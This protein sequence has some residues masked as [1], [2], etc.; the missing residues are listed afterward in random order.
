MFCLLRLLRV[1]VVS[2]L[3]DGR[4][5][6]SNTREPKAHTVPH[7]PDPPIKTENDESDDPSGK[8]VG[9]ERIYFLYTVGR[10]PFSSVSR[11]QIMSSRE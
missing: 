9:L 4:L 1:L 2:S 10:G 3:E 7:D 11:S 8:Q 5:V 6:A